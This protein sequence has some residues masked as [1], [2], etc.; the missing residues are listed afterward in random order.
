[1]RVRLLPVPFALAIVVACVGTDQFTGSGTGTGIGS[2]VGDAGR[3]PDGGLVDGGTNDA[4]TTDGGCNTQILPLG[5]V[6]ANDT[7]AIPGT[8]VVTTATIIP[9][10][11]ADVTITMGLNDGFN[12]H[13]S[14]S[15]AANA[16]NGFCNTNPCTSTR[17]PGTITCTLA[18]QTTCNIAICTDS[19]GTNCPP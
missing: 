19:A 6:A 3:L 7:C 9:A 1:M 8:T 13:G 17:L 15:T 12:C 16:F 14:L 2:G 18:N 4:G 11:C 10:G 5:A